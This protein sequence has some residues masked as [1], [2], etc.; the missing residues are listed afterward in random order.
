M[1][2]R[3]CSSFLLLALLLL[4]ARPARPELT[5]ERRHEL[6]LAANPSD[7]QFHLRLT[8]EAKFHPGELIP[9]TFEFS[10]TTP[11]KYVL[12]G[13]T[14][15]RSGRLP[16]EQFV[17][18]SADVLDPFLDYFGSGV[19]GG[20][21]G[22]HNPKSTL[23][24]EPHRIELAMNQ[25]CRFDKP[26][27]Y[28]LYSRTYRISRTRQ[29]SDSVESRLYFAAVSNIIEI[30]IMQPYPGWQTTKL[31][32]IEMILDRATPWSDDPNVRQAKA[33][34][35]YLGTRGAVQ[36]NLNMA[37][38]NGYVD[39]LGLIGALDRAFVISELDRYIEDPNASVTSAIISLRNLFDFVASHPNP[40]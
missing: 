8:H 30:E 14:S 31:R 36:L 3:H 37:R 10:S 39:A 19:M 20:L 29:P 24:T 26:G 34:L 15:D 1:E 2:I 18:E 6:E 27:R 5:F 12:S 25:W 38:R 11:E 32:E 22:G 21:M 17:S 13:A 23:S 35:A 4:Q 28:R 9:L 7:L 40:L 16:T 33:E